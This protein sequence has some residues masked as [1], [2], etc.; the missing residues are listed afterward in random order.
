MAT[1]NLEDVCLSVCLFVRSV[2]LAARRPHSR[3]AGSSAND[4]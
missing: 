2:L 3:S 4:K 1:D